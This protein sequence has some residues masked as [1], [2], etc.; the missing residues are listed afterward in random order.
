[1][2][3]ITVFCG[4]NSGFRSE[5]A[6]AAKRLGNLFVS[7]GIRLVYGGGKVGLMGVIADEVMRGG[8]T[9]VGIIPDSLE[10]KEVGHREVT[11]LLVVDSMHERKAKMAEFADGFIAMPGGIGTFE[12]FFE[13][14]TW[15]QLGFHNKP[16]GILNIAGYYDG[17]LALCD[18]AVTEGFL[19]REHRQLIIEDSDPELLLSKMKEFE[20]THLE[21][22]LQKENL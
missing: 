20:P 19:R 21:K 22:W 1:M 18:N 13:I 11:E 12:E 16:C 6:E 15:A 7:A 10:R 9:V 2:K 3:S 8:G 5:Y 14:L 17:L 4:S